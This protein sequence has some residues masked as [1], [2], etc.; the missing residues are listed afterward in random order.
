M[1]PEKSTKL[2]LE[3]FFSN[4]KL[5]RR[6]QMFKNKNDFNKMTKSEDGLQTYCKECHRDYMR[7]YMKENV[8][9]NKTSEKYQIHKMRV[10]MNRISIP[11]DPKDYHK[12][13]EHLE[14]KLNCSIQFYYEW[15]KYQRSGR[16]GRSGIGKEIDHEEIDHVLPLAKFKQFPDLCNSWFNM[17]P[18]SRWFNRRKSATV[19]WPLFKEQLD[20]SIRFMFKMKN[21]GWFSLR[22]KD[23]IQRWE[24]IIFKYFDNYQEYWNM[25]L[26]NEQWILNN[27]MKDGEISK[28]TIDRMI[29][30]NDQLHFNLA[31]IKLT[32]PEDLASNFLSFLSKYY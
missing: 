29:Y 12:Q 13:V 14:D 23:V 24:E 19:I 18:V 7:T 9:A 11:K 16:S 28:E 6:C 1:V 26:L 4:L 3:E 25:R 15:L 30:F 31:T 17:K 21:N 32:T 27:K 22:D 5:C 10:S 2:V 20:T 8:Y